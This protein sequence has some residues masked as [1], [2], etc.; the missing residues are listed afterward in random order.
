LDSPDH[1]ARIR[2]EVEK[3]RQYLKDF[4][5]T[6]GVRN[7]K[8]VN[9]GRAV[10]DS[11]AL[12]EDDD[13]H[14]WVNDPVHPANSAYNAIAE[15]LIEQAGAL[16]GGGNKR[17]GGDNTDNRNK[18]HQASPNVDWRDNRGPT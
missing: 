12:D 9:L 15:M 5:W 14:L 8:V 16:K 7:V 3:S 4:A 13:W 17:K 18:R 1:R 10:T 11:T 6:C 2:D